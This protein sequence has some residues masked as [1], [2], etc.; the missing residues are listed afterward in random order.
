MTS[1]DSH[2]D[3]H[4]DALV[5]AKRTRIVIAAGVLALAIVYVGLT[6]SRPEPMTYTPTPPELQPAEGRLVGPVTFTVDARDGARWQFFSFAQGALV[7]NP[8]PFEWD[9]AFRRFQVI[10]NGGPGFAGL[11]GVQDLGSV[12]F[13]SLVVVPQDGYSGTDVSRSDSIAAPLEDWYDYSYFSH[14]LNPR[15]AVFA[16]RTGDGRYAKLRFQGYYC[17]GAQ[18]G[19]VTFEYVYQGAGGP[20]LAHGA[21]D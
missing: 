21:V 20:D 13:D 6:L 16:L 10:V 5:R 15:P 2:P 11:G 7:E 9:L 17:P 12:S 3:S 4:A 1:A 18:P 14:L 19:C 8:R